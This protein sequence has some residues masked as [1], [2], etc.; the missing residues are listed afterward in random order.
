LVVARLL[1]IR[2]HRLLKGGKAVGD[3]ALHGGEFLFH[4]SDFILQ[5]G[6]LRI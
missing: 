1:D 3:A 6:D 4:G 2:R 5:S